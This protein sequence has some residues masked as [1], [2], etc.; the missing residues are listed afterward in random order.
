MEI[1][2]QITKSHYVD[3]LPSPVNSLTEY[4]V[5]IINIINTLK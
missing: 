1:L 4:I 2:N 3:R 5:L